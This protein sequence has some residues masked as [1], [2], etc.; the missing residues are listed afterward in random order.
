MLQALSM[1]YLQT[2]AY[3]SKNADCCGLQV[4]VRR[5]YAARSGL[6]HEGCLLQAPV[7]SWKAICCQL[8]TKCNLQ[9]K[10]QKSRKADGRKLQIDVRR[11]CCTGQAE[12]SMKA[13]CCK[14]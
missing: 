10:S 2:K 3:K 13:V 6:K 4:D 14:L 5:L 9:P 7:E 8:Q 11:L 12:G 1:M